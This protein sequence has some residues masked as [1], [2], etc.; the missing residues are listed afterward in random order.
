M[1]FCVTPCFL[2]NH[3]DWGVIATYENCNGLTIL[4]RHR[5]C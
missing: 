2:G 3:E 1:I 4:E 5:A